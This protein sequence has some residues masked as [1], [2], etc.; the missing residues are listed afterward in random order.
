MV[1]QRPSR[2]ATGIAMGNSEGVE[3]ALGPLIRLD[4]W[5]F[6]S[7]NYIVCWANGPG[8]AHEDRQSLLEE[9]S[10]I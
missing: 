5:I 7:G 4:I 6:G 2:A 9:L 1:L 10:V 8:L 3:L